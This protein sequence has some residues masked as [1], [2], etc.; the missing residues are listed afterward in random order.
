[1][2]TAKVSEPTV[3]HMLQPESIAIGLVVL[4]V[5]LA[6]L[7]RRAL[8]GGSSADA[9]ES[10]ARHEA[11]RERDPPV[12]VGDVESAGVHEFTTH[13]SGARHAVCK[14]E[15]FV[16]FVEDLPDDLAVADPI[17]FKILSFNRGR[18]SASATFLERAG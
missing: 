18:T 12:A 14:V 10:S 9:R 17:R 13:H 1:M 4:A 5:P 2:V 16:I 7:A 3:G 6:W 11:A 8:G 15:G